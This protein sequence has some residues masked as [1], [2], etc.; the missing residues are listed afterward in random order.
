LELSESKLAGLRVQHSDIEKGLL[1]AAKKDMMMA[2][3]L[4][5]AEGLS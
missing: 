1:L 4:E 3:M 2:G 5:G